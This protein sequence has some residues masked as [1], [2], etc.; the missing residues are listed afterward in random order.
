MAATA[1]PAMCETERGEA[2]G[3]EWGWLGFQGGREQ[4]R[5]GLIG[6]GESRDGRQRGHPRSG[7]RASTPAGGGRRPAGG[8]GLALCDLGP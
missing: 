3:G 4:L 8:L 1:S 5:F 7:V 6:A 2:S